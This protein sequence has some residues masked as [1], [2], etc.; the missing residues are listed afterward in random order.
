MLGIGHCVDRLCEGEAFGPILQLLGHLAEGPARE[1]LTAAALGDGTLAARPSRLA[2]LEGGRGFDTDAAARCDYVEP[3]GAVGPRDRRL[4]CTVSSVSS[5]AHPVQGD[6]SSASRPT[7]SEPRDP[8]PAPGT[9]PRATIAT[10]AQRRAG[11]ESVAAGSALER[12]VAGATS[13]L[14]RIA[15]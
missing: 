1:R 4:P 12:H 15:L 5:V 14:C 8:D 2:G 3:P 13:L 10:V 9:S 11:G 7:S 6:R